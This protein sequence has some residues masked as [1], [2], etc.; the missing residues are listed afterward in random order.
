MTPVLRALLFLPLISIT[1]FL[2][3][4]SSSKKNYC[5]IC[6]TN[7]NI[8]YG[9]ENSNTSVIA[10]DKLDFWTDANLHV[11][12]VSLQRVIIAFRSI[13]LIKIITFILK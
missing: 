1:V 4:D 11:I 7:P 10:K 2:N 5:S 8:N 13:P 12:L 3:E 6:A 9:V